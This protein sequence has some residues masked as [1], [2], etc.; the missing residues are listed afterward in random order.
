M[1]TGR[2]AKVTKNRIIEAMEQ[3]RNDPNVLNLVPELAMLRGSL[4]VFIAGTDKKEMSDKT[5]GLI[6]K[7]IDSIGNMVD[8]IDKIQSRQTLTA[9]SARLLMLR[10]V[11][12]AKLYI[13]EEKVSDFILDW[14]GMTSEYNLIGPGE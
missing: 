10:A 4:E 12:I 3:H 6:L 1:T 7:T 8:K 5:I 11:D 13:P 14:K 2:Y 9:A